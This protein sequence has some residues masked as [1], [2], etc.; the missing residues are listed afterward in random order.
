MLATLGLIL[1]A[2]GWIMQVRHMRNDNCLCIKFVV[3]Y[4][5]G[6]LLL[7][8]EGL[9]NGPLWMVLLN[10]VSLVAALVVL[11]KLKKTCDCKCMGKKTAAKPKRK[12]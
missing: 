6:V 2:I 1:I 8:L 10:L 4:S 11:N 5:I 7:V 9:W 3:L 12:R